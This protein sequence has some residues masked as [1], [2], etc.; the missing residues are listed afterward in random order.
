MT[1]NSGT[2]AIFFAYTIVSVSQTQHIDCA[3]CPVEEQRHVLVGME[4][5]WKL[6]LS[7]NTLL[8]C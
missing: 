7:K 8:K 2:F 5:G 1:F 4:G 3:Q 6:R